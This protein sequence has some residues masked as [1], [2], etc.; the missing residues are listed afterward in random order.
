MKKLLPVIHCQTWNQTRENI[1]RANEAG[2][3]GAFLIN[4]KIPHQ[5]LSILAERAVKEFPGFPIGLNYLDLDPILALAAMP[6]GIT[7][8][9]TD[10]PY[11]TEK[12]GFPQGQAQ[13]FLDYREARMSSVCYYGSVAFKYKP[14]VVD[15]R[16][17]T[18]IAAKYMEVVTTSGDAT[19]VAAPIS[20][21]RAMKEVLG[22]KSLALASGVDSENVRDYLPYVDDFLVAT[23]ISYDFFNLNQDKVKELADIIHAS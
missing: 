13:M 10:E 15:L 8:L 19:G 6:D 5:F 14:P 1:R 7:A 9:W 17:M 20:K 21:V 16:L 11:L 12:P 4:H 22:N 2:A 18:M 23:G 3:D